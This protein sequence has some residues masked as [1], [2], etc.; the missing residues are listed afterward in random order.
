MTGLPDPVVIGRPR[1]RFLLLSFIDKV[2]I[3]RYHN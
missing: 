1:P 3:K 2:M